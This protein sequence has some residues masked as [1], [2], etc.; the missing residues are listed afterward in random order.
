M[1]NRYFPERLVAANINMEQF[2]AELADEMELEAALPDDAARK[3]AKKLITNPVTGDE[4]GPEPE[5]KGM[6]PG[7]G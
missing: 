4:T 2:H 3:R 7:Q 1:G 5:E 6:W